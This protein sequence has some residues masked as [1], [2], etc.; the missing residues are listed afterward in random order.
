MWILFVCLP[1]VIFGAAQD[2]TAY[3]VPWA[4]LSWT[5]KFTSGHS[6]AEEPWIQGALKYTQMN[7]IYESTWPI[8]SSTDHTCLGWSAGISPYSTEHVLQSDLASVMAVLC[9]ALVIWSTPAILTCM[10]QVKKYEAVN[11]AAV[12]NEKPQMVFIGLT[13][14]NSLRPAATLYMHE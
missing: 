12:A 11:M 4:V 5:L 7:N 1:P 6:W 8:A 9:K 3:I 10:T 13:S 2:V 14:H